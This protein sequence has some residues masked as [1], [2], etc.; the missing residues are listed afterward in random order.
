MHTIS[1]VTGFI[2]ALATI[3][4]SEELKGSDV[5]QAC[6][7]IC[8]P[9]V[10]LTNTCDINPDGTRRRMLRRQA[11]NDNGKN[12]DESDEP[13]EAQCVCQNTSFNVGRI[14][15]LCAACLTQNKAKTEGGLHLSSQAPLP[16]TDQLIN[17]HLD[18]RYE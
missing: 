10:T 7:A 1:I 6:T 5:P 3:V 16:E 14:A 8:G 11:D 12:E 15:A 13:I 9:I 4:S 2:T 17:E 18:L